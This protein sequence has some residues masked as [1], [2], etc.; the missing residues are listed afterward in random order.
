LEPQS[1]AFFLLLIVIFGGLMWWLGVGS[2]D[3]SDLRNAEV[4]EQLLQV[5]QP[6]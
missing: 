2:G 3:R 6:G 4:F 1:T 5:R